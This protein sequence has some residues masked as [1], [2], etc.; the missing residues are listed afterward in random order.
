MELTVPEGEYLADKWVE[1][2]CPLGEYDEHGSAITYNR[3]TIKREAIQGIILKKIQHS[4]VLEQDY[5]SRV[6]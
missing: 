3:F 6:H 1:L 4:K 2:E 5:K